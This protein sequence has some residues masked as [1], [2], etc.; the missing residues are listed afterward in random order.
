MTEFKDFNIRKDI[1][2]KHGF[3]VCMWHACR[4]RLFF[5]HLFY[6]SGLL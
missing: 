3:Q 4:K 2:L 5:L 1:S 6:R